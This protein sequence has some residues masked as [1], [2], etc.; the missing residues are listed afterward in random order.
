[1][2]LTPTWVP[3]PTHASQTNISKFFN[4]FYDIYYN[5]YFEY[6]NCNYPIQ[7]LVI[8]KFKFIY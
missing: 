8:K 6:R 7:D 5:I 4:I 1:M 2:V 3:D